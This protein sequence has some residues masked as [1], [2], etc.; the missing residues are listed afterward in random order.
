M[1]YNYIIITPVRD[2]EIVIEN[3]LRSVTKQTIQPIKWI[4]INDNSVD[5]T[6]NIILKWKKIFP[7]IDVYDF[8]EL[9]NRL[10]GTGVVRAFDYGIKKITICEYDFIIKLDAD[11]SFNT[12]YFNCLFNEFENNTK[13]GIAS[14][15]IYELNGK[16][17][18]KNIEEH[19]YGASKIYRT[20]CFK[21]IYPYDH[22]KAWDLLDN[23]KANVAGFETKII[24]SQ[25]VI[26][27]KPM[28]SAVGKYSEN[29]LK[30]Y[31][32]AYLKYNPFFAFLKGL[33]VILEKPYLIGGI[34]FFYGYLE[35]ILF[36]KEF[37]NGNQVTNY[38][39][40]QQIRR[41]KRLFKLGN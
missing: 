34:L 23:I 25:K 41:L 26:H 33:K 2:E 28:E 36:K 4:F 9:T 18:K 40:A 16:P 8:P 6:K 15:M 27:H 10:P 1:Q 14:G 31:Y 7:F 17:V 24:F 38:L 19:P 20:K 39:K 30:G 11:L 3:T 22:I 32:S 12:D 5:N 37:Y 21:K 35:N 29:R 13:L